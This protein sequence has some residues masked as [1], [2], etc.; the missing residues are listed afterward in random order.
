[1]RG[2]LP[3]FDDDT[4]ARCSAATIDIIDQ[5]SAAHLCRQR[6]TSST[7]ESCCFC[8]CKYLNLVALLCCRRRRCKIM[9]CMCSPKRI[10]LY[11]PLQYNQQ[12]SFD[13]HH[14]PTSRTLTVHN[15]KDSANIIYSAATIDIIDQAGNL[16]AI[17]NAAAQSYN[18]SADRIHTLI[19]GE[20][21]STSSTWNLVAFASANI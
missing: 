10:S 18:D 13:R 15:N 7:W 20:S 1:M 9:C 16:S 3:A 19:Y 12:L 4:L 21:R 8:F 14:R 2:G 6:S 5:D 11:W 17:D